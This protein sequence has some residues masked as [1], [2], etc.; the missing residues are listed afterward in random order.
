VSRKPREK[1]CGDKDEGWRWK[2]RP[3]KRLQLKRRADCYS[4]IR[5]REPSHGKQ[6]Q[7]LVR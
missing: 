3:E 2:G 6:H 7:Q 5:L 4:G 1:A